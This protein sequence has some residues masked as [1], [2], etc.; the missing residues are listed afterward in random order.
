MGGLAG[1]R[2]GKAERP[3]GLFVGGGFGL[4]VLGARR[5]G[6]RFGGRLWLGRRL[7]DRLRLMHRRQVIADRS[8]RDTDD[9]GGVALA[10]LGDQLRV[11]DAVAF[12]VGAEGL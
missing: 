12:G 10:D 2:L 7:G 4:G 1:V 5:R 9:V 3:L 6:L 8:G 11:F